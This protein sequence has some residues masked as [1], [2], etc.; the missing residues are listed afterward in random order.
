[1]NESAIFAIDFF[2]I[3]SVASVNYISTLFMDL[4]MKPGTDH[5]RWR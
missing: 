1:M 2:Y 4:H 5:H 3:M